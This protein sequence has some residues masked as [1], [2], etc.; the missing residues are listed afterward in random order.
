MVESVRFEAVT[1]YDKTLIKRITKDRKNQSTRMHWRNYWS[2]KT[3]LREAR[4]KKGIAECKR[5]VRW[6]QN[7]YD[8]KW[9]TRR[10][11]IR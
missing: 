9:E 2:L 5:V 8:R 1:D 6:Y 10:K 11:Q 3:K 7:L 4:K